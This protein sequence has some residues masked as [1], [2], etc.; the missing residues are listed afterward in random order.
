MLGDR[1]AAAGTAF[2]AV[3][4]IGAGASGLPAARHLLREGVSRVVVYE[5]CPRP[6]GVWNY[7]PKPAPQPSFPSLDPVVADPAI[8]PPQ[9]VE[10]PY[11]EVISKGDAI[12]GAPTPGPCYE[13]LRNNVATPLM[14]YKDF[15]WPESTKW[16]TGH[17]NIARYLQEYSA[18]F[19]IDE[20]TKYNTVV[21]DVRKLPVG[22]SR[23]WQVISRR[24]ESTGDRTEL[25]WE[26]EKLLVIGSGASGLDIILNSAGASAIFHSTRSDQEFSSAKKLLDQIQLANLRPVPNVRAFRAAP[27]SDATVEDSTVEF[28]DGTTETGFTRVV[29]CTGYMFSHPF[30]AAE[31]ERGADAGEDDTE[32]ATRDGEWVRNLY[33]DIFYAADPS[34]AFVGVP[35]HVAT[36]S[37]FE[38]LAIAV[39]RVFTGKAALPNE[40]ERRRQITE[41]LR[42][43]G[44]G[45][46]SHLIGRELEPLEIE[47]LLHWL[48]ED[49]EALGASPIE[50]PDAEYFQTREKAPELFLAETRARLI[51]N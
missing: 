16:F 45:R 32:L 37:Y 4:V 24:T 50:G 51:S 6:G 23:K 18:K 35:F 3:A 41:K 47:K 49:A 39:A 1:H 11:R 8:R 15:E 2:E 44:P 48:N 42:A 12:V 29:L 10:F 13:T 25:I 40:A 34:L 17:E 36:F 38:Y 31:R 19:G 22:G 30:L 5:R 9:G 7:D 33:R 20:I 28:A 27:G 43:T 46:K 14:R 26:R 21:V